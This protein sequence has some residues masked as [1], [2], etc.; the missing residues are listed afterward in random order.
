MQTNE[1]Q[2]AANSLGIGESIIMGTA[3][4]APAFSISLGTATLIGVVGTLSP[5]SLLYCGLMMFGITLAFIHLNKIMVNAG[6][7]YAW[8]SQIFGK[9]LGYFAGWALLVASAVFM[10]SGSTP[11]ATATLLLFAPQLVNDLNWVTFIAA[12]WITLIAAVIYKGIKGASILQIIMTAVELFV[13]IAVIIGGIFRFWS[14]PVHVL[15]WSSFSLFDFTPGLFATGALTAVFFYWGWDVTLNLNEET[16]NAKHA[17]GL[18]AFW[19]ILIIIALFVSF[20]V[21]TL[22]VLNDQEIHDAGPN[23]VFAVTNKIF[24]EPW[25]YLAIICV[26]F[27]TVGTIETTILQFTRT[28]YALGR[29][30]VLHSR[31]ARLHPKWSTP[32]QAIIFIWIFGLLFLF[33]SSYFPTI[34]VLIKDSVNAIGFQ[35]AFYY[36]L[37]GFACAWYYRHKWR[38]VI[39]LFGYILWPIMSALFLIFIAIRSVPTFDLTTNLIGIGGLLFGY[40]PF[41]LNKNHLKR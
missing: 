12:L 2:L 15:T 17:P 7:S 18:G 4:A 22:F 9:Q 32:W 35:V 34:N 37:T 25:G 21:A 41:W 23:L 1:R 10:V 16:K 11:A 31:Y 6:A 20:I 40:I 14:H 19:S 30:E 33:L 38:K 13:L 5:A 24:P 3:G 36:S 27:S 26:I 39:E 29:D 8:V 28:L